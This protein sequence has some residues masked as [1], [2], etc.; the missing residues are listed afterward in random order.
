MSSTERSSGPG[1][2]GKVARAALGLIVVAAAAG[3]VTYRIGLWRPS[4]PADPPAKVRPVAE[5]VA[6][7]GKTVT[8][9]AAGAILPGPE[10]W[11]QARRDGGGI[12]DFAPMMAGAKKT[13]SAADLALCHLGT[14]LAAEGPFSGP[15]RYVAPAGVAKAIADTGFDGCATASEDALDRGPAGLARTLDALDQ[16]KVGHSGTY[17]S[18]AQSQK[19]RLYTANG[20]KVAHL[21]Y[22]L[23]LN[24]GKLPAERDWSV[25]RATEE[26]VRND[27]RDARQAGASIVVV[28]IDWGSETEHEPD[29]DQQ[30]LARAIATM[31]DVDVVFGFGAHVVQPAE[32]IGDKWVL[33]GLGDFLSRHPQPVNGNREGTMMRVTFSAGEQGDGWKVR[34]VEAL[35]TFIDLNPGIRVVD[36]EQALADPG[37]PAGRRRIYEAAVDRIESHVLNRGAAGTVLKVRATSR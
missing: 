14:P 21:S 7:T 10:V 32:R 15:P 22:T 33:Y 4:G 5:P 36:L 31:D 20:V 30:E 16:A 34:A 28:S 3:V 19:P 27:A 11:D 8:I 37:V 25:A 2:G 6:A 17:K 9:L 29:V 26:K 12:F 23:T 18:K 13:V 35:P 24:G 1:P